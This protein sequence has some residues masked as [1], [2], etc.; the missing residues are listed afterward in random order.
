MVTTYKSD[1]RF[2]YVDEMST[3]P[4]GHALRRT[5][6]PALWAAMATS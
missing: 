2:A 6:S 3:M 4:S 5:L 1:P